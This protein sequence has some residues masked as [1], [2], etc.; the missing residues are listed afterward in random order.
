MLDQLRSGNKR[1]KAI[2]LALIIL[3]VGSFVGGFIFMAGVGNNSSRNAQMSGALG[4]VNGE[5]ITPEMYRMALEEARL[6][7]R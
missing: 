6:G 1:I 5:K 3:T 7:F 4:S 2:W